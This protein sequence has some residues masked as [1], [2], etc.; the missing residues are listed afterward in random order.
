MPVEYGSVTPNVAAAA[1][2]ASTAL[3]PCWSTRSPAR[4]ASG[5]TVLTAPPRPTAVACFAVARCAAGARSAA[6]AAPTTGGPVSRA[7]GT[8]R[9]VAAASSGRRGRVMTT[10]LP[11]S[12]QFGQRAVHQVRVVGGQPDHPRVAP[13]PGLLPPDEPPGGPH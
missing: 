3:P 1:T 4:V 10:S 13:E 9:A 7:A 11:G 5:S 6:P 12:G 8:T 2:A